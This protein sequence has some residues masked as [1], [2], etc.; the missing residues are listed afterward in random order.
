MN[1]KKRKHPI[2]DETKK[3]V[4]T[5]LPIHPYREQIISKL[6]S[7]QKADDGSSSG[8]GGAAYGSILLVTAQTG[9]GKSTQ[10]PLFLHEYNEMKAKKKV[11]GK[12]HGKYGNVIGVTQPRRVAAMSVAKRVAEEQ[13]CILG[14]TVGYRVR[15]DDNSSP[16]KTR[17]L[18]L[19]DGMLLRESMSDPLLSKYSTIVLDEAHERSLQTDVLFGVVKRALIARRPLRKEGD[20]GI[21]CDNDPHGKESKDADKDKLIQLNMRKRARQLNIPP[22]KIVVMSATLDTRTFLDFFPGSSMIDIPGRQYPVDIVYTD[23]VQ[24]DYVDAAFW[25]VMQIHKE[26]DE[27]GDILVFLPGQEEIEDLSILLRRHLDEDADLTHSITTDTTLNEKEKSVN[28]DVVQSLKGIGTDLSSGKNSIVNGVMV[29]SLYAALPPEQQMFAFQPKPP[30]CTRKIILSTNIAETS[31]TL[32]GISYV[33]DCGKVKTRDFS[34]VTGMERLAVTNTSKS[35]ATQRAGRAGRMSAGL[36]FRLYPE[37]AFGS[38]NDKATPEILRVNLAQVVLQLKGMGVHDPR[39][40]DFLTPPN[41][42]SLL[43][44]FELLYA[45]GAIDAKM[46]L[47]DRGKNMA[48]LPLDPMFA[49]LLLCGPKFRCTSELLSVVAMF[50]AE[51]IFYRPGG[52]SG[53]NDSLSSKAAA[54]H[55]RF[56]SYEGDIPT[57]LCVYQAWRNEA[58][59]VRPSAGGLKAQRKLLK[60]EKLSEDRNA[61]KA[62]V[63]MNKMLHGEWCQR[64]FISGRAITRAHDVR[65]QLVEICSRLGWDVDISCGTELENLLKG[66]CAGLFMQV[67]SRI[68]LPQEIKRKQ[69]RALPEQGFSGGRYKTKI[70]GQEVSIHPTSTMFARNPKPKCVVYTELLVTKKVYIRGVTQVKEDW[71][72]EVAPQ[73]FK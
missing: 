36:C 29:C 41:S 20:D 59:Y 50:S 69:N 43:K 72:S 39:K 52:S 27:N 18:Y 34:G 68:M 57:L 10:I 71:L 40:F 19:T 38:L 14:T 24:E 25:T 67:A 15:F 66:V 56:A 62:K 7:K 8:G 37:E 11:N 45:L 4:K 64:N 47:T 1:G 6:Y 54:A 44:A 2:N 51:N 31:V 26:A 58:I 13:G 42:Q 35:Q 12:Y 5:E 46:E 17:I 21:S 49:N 22:L 61:K 16:H 60:Q 70:G 53:G 63:G 23:E 48:K 9:S 28:A 3:A 32:E 73:F 30:D 33:V 65:N 55:R